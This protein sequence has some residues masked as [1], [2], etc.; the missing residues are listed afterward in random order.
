MYKSFKMQ[1]I[2][3]YTFIITS[4]LAFV[5]ALFFMTQYRDL[6]GLKLKLNEAISLFHDQYMQQINKSLFV[7]AIFGIVILGFGYMFEI[8]RKV[9]DVFALIVMCS[10]LTFYASCSAYFI[11]KINEAYNKYILL[12]FQNMYLEGPSDYVLR[13]ETF[14]IGY[15]IYS[16]IILVSVTYCISMINSHIQYVKK[17]L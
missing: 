15:V 13:T 9:P 10:S 4:I 16:I 8:N 14:Y 5:Y 11:F 6:F 1:K 2:S 17:G 12:D 3:M 7:V